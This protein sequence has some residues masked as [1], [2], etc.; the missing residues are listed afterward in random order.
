MA[1]HADERAEPADSYA[2]GRD[3]EFD[4]ALL[5]TDAVYAIAM[6]LLVVGI[7]VPT[8]SGDSDSPRAMLD[9]LNEKTSEFISF[10]VAF[11]IIG[12]YWLAHHEF[13]AQLRSVDRM[14][15]SINL[16]YL[17]F[18]AFLPFP[19]A[20]IGRYEENPISLVLFAGT[21]AIVSL[22]EVLLFQYAWRRG[23]TKR[24][25][26]KEVA[27]WGTAAASVPVLIFLISMP[28]A[29]LLSPTA[30]LV[31][32]LLFIPV[33]VVVDRLRPP[34]TKDYFGRH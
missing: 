16:V 1:V 19:T 26:P 2:R 24:V 3:L 22:L 23:H 32:W 30:A 4:R 18:V 12:R 17:A 27:R 13:V 5:F 6:T 20:L 9:A 34:G 14:L 28:I 15:I 33:M 21:L 29:F 10:F 11:W 31:S 8:V 25:I 7:A